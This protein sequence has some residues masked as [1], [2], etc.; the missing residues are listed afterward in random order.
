MDTPPTTPVF[1]QLYQAPGAAQPPVSD[2]LAI[3]SLVLGIC[4]L[5]LFCVWHIALPAAIAGLICAKL[6]PTHT[7]LRRAGMIC[8]IIALSLAGV[9][10]LLAIVGFGIM[11][12]IAAAA[13]GRP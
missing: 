12:L 3:A 11:G 13:A 7:P 1:N 5:V 8:S 6:S 2:G 4:S 9:A 10:L